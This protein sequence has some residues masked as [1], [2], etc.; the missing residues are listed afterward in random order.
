MAYVHWAGD[1]R[2]TIVVLTR[3]RNPGLNSNS[4]VWISRDYSRT[5]ENR[6][7]AFKQRNGDFALID[8]FYP[9]PV[10]NTKVS[11]V[12]SCWWMRDAK[13][14]ICKHA[15]VHD[16]ILNGLDQRMSFSSFNLY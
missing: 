8:M 2:D 1:G 6:T 5:F 4:H 15:A 9:S 14:R 7:N 10:D 11:I 12:K 13:G 16:C 3:D